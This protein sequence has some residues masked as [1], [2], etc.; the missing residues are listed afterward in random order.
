[1]IEELLKLS[2]ELSK[3]TDKESEEY[4]VA[5]LNLARKLQEHDYNKLKEKS[6]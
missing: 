6:E 3:I 1:M 4:K 5:F 2:R